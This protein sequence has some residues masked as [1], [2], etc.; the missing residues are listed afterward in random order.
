M[1]TYYDRELLHP[2]HLSS[3]DNF[4]GFVW[5]PGRHDWLF[6]V[7][8]TSIHYGRHHHDTVEWVDTSQRYDRVFRPDFYIEIVMEIDRKSFVDLDD[9]IESKR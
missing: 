3:V 5:H 6:S 2:E 9:I 7:H 4:V 8:V 1:N